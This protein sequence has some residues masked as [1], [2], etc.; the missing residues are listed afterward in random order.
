MLFTKAVKIIVI[1]LILRTY[2][3]FEHNTQP[4]KKPKN[5]YNNQSIEIRS[6]F[7]IHNNMRIIHKQKSTF[8]FSL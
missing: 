4:F 5:G 1:L 2:E 8:L 7:I 3:H 6:G